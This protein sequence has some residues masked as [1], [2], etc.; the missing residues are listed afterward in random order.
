MIMPIGNTQRSV[1]NVVQFAKDERMELNGKK[2]KEM[3]QLDFGLQ[4]SEEKNR[5]T[6]D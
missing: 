1:N 4:F 6:T 2:C 5:N 3:L